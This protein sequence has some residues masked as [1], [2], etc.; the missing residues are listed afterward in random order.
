MLYNLSGTAILAMES[1]SGIG[2]LSHTDAVVV[3]HS[4]KECRI[5]Y[6]ETTFPM[7]FDMFPSA[8]YSCNSCAVADTGIRR[9]EP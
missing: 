9:D 5:T 2:P 1:C 4:A 6:L 7:L 3:F 8:K